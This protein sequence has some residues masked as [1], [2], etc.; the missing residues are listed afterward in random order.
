MVRPSGF[1]ARTSFSAV[2]PTFRLKR[3]ISR[4]PI[5]LYSVFSADKFVMQS[6]PCWMVCWIS[7]R[8]ALVHTMVRSSAKKPCCSPWM[9]FSRLLNES[10]ATMNSGSSTEP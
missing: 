9:Q 8:S 1:G 3:F 4:A 10:T 2:S 5:G 6:K 7:L